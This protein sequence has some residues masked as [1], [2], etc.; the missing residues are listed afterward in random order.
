MQSP[1][2]KISMDSK[3]VVDCGSGQPI[4]RSFVLNYVCF[5][6]DSQFQ[7]LASRVKLAVKETGTG[8]GK[9]LFA[10]D[11]IPENA[12]IVRCDANVADLGAYINDPMFRMA[13]IRNAHTHDEMHQALRVLEAEYYDELLAQ[14]KINV[15]VG[16]LGFGS[17]G[18]I[19]IKP[20]SKGDELFR[21]YGFQPWLFEIWDHLTEKNIRGYHRFLTEKTSGIELALDDDVSAHTSLLQRDMSLF[22]MKT[23]KL[24][25]DKYFET[26]DFTFAT[27]EF[28]DCQLDKVSGDRYPCECPPGDPVVLGRIL[29][30]LVSTRLEAAQVAMFVF[31][32]P[33]KCLIM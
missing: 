27:D 22:K 26:G 8:M 13:S 28:R 19:T 20:V 5:R 31:D 7:D 25:L 9:G 3:Q 11:D 17:T 14:Q 24:I 33:G 15:V 32:S 18:Y 10:E 16:H 2:Q 12:L 6:K 4:P 30:Q 21:V 29:E 1:P 23:T